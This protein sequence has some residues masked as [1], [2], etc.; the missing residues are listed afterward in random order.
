MGVDFQLVFGPISEA[1]FCQFLGEKRL[2][3]IGKRKKEIGSVLRSLN[4]H[5]GI[6]FGQIFA[7]GPAG[8]GQFL[9]RLEANI[10]LNND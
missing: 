5:L 2:E 1:V 3:K 8:R 7:S 10:L 4:C 9:N 6:I